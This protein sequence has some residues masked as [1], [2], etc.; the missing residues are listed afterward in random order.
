MAQEDRRAFDTELLSSLKEFKQDIKEDI[1]EIKDELKQ[2]D[3]KVK[4]HVDVNNKFYFNG[5][6]PDK[7]VADHHVIDSIIEKV[8]EGKSLKNKLI[9]EVLKYVLIAAVTWVAYASWDKF[10]AEI[11]PP[12]DSKPKVEQNDKNFR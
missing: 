5:F 4:D 9:E 2:I 6:Q 8:N 3:R 11:K 12:V 10:N 1:K 7:H